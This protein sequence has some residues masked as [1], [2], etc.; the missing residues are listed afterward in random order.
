MRAL[1]IAALLL[2][3]FGPAAWG[4]EP[5]SPDPFDP[6]SLNEQALASVAAG[7]LGGARIL[8]ERAARL[9]PHDPRIL[10]N[11]RLLSEEMEA[12]APLGKAE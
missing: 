3:A 11:L 2:T 6:V 10:D 12:S 9:A 1:T 7:D 8:L 4:Q 5:L